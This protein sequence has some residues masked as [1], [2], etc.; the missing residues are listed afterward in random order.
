M[1]SLLA[2]PTCALL[3]APVMSLKRRLPLLVGR[4]YDSL[5]TRGQSAYLDA[6]SSTRAISDAAKASKPASKES[7]T[8]WIKLQY[9]PLVNAPSPG[10]FD[11][12]I[13]SA[14]LAC[15]MYSFVAGIA[16]AAKAVRRTPAGPPPFPGYPEAQL[17]LHAAADMQAGYSLSPA[18]MEALKLAVQ[19]G[20]APSDPLQL[21]RRLRDHASLQ[22][23]FPGYS[24]E[25]Q[26]CSDASVFAYEGSRMHRAMRV[27][28]DLAPRHLP[29]VG[30]LMARM[31]GSIARGAR[32]CATKLHLL[33]QVCQTYI[34]CSFPVE[35]LSPQNC[36]LLGLM[37]RQLTGVRTS[38]IHY[39]IEHGSFRGWGGS[40]HHDDAVYRYPHS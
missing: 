38:T 39:V 33:E 15:V 28:L 26:L 12:A 27:F 19:R 22:A 8:N 3:L 32:G 4:L 25:E 5:F 20:D 40:I 13:E 2:C 21:S 9:P 1:P 31:G 18:A 16:A 34:G 36:Q 37:D 14:E 6:C 7:L 10:K 30:Q 29:P 23:Q 24:L 17:S 11:K 35:S